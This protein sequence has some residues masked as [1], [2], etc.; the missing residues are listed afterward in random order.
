MIRISLLNHRS[1][2]KTIRVLAEY[3]GLIVRKSDTIHLHQ[4]STPSTNE[5]PRAIKI[6]FHP[7]VGEVDQ[8]LSIYR[9]RTP[10]KEL[11]KLHLAG[12]PDPT[13]HWAVIVGSY[14]YEFAPDNNFGVLYR[15]GDISGGPHVWKFY[16]VGTTKYN[17]AAINTAV[18]DKTEEVVASKVIQRMS[19][20][21]DILTNNCQTFVTNLLDIICQP[22]RT[23]IIT[24]SPGK[25]TDYGGFIFY[26]HY[27]PEEKT[28]VEN[29]IKIMKD[30]TPVIPLPKGRRQRSYEELE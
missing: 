8:L 24:P 30:N 14:C 29:A 21:Y 7:T 28:S 4:C 6:G 5:P 20:D 3:G 18:R 26:E 19:K 27:H 13:Y 25:D 2:L 15:R 16:R 10:F 23:E 1:F 22:G 17:D 12:A 11:G 9:S